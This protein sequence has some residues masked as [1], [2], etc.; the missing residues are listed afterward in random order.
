MDEFEY[1]N[2]KYVKRGFPSRIGGEGGDPS[3]REGV[4]ID[5]L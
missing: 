1:F 3:S 4:N 2:N 5:V